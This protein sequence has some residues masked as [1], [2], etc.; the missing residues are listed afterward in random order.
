MVI[1]RGSSCAHRR[2]IAFSTLIV[3]LLAAHGALPAP[4][5]VAR[6]LQHAVGLRFPCES[7][8]CGC[9]TADECWSNC[10]CHTEHERLV[11]AIREGVLPPA[12]LSFT[13]AQWIA[14]A[15]A[16]EPGSAHCGG[17]V[18]GILEKLRR[19]EP[20]RVCP[21]SRVATTSCCAPRDPDHDSE[22]PQKSAGAPR[23]SPLRCK[24]LDPNMS[25]ALVAL[26][27]LD[28]MGMTCP[29]PQQTACSDDAQHPRSRGITPPAPPPRASHLTPIRYS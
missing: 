26:L 24:S 27:P 23:F 10:C 4:V 25:M 14:A 29:A 1:C 6:L 18:A 13:D 22:A 21:P 5:T 15:N 8:G 9:A 20:T 28:D 12:S 19:S 17:C 16:V 3:Y 7:C 11:W 2:V